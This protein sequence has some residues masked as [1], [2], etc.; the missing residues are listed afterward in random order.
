M[1]ANLITYYQNGQTPIQFNAQTENYIQQDPFL[2]LTSPFKGLSFPNSPNIVLGPR[3]VNFQFNTL[4]NTTHPYVSPN[5]QDIIDLSNYFAD[6]DC[7]YDTQ[8]GE[9][10]QIIVQVP[11][12][13]IS[14][15][16]FNIS[17]YASEQWELIPNRDIKSVVA[18]GIIC[19][20]FASPTIAGNYVVLP[21]VMK[22]AVERAYENKNTVLT[23]P[24]GSPASSASFLPYAN[25]TLNLLRGGIEGVPSVTHTLKRTAVIDNRNSNGAFQT[26]ADTERAFINANGTVNYI[27]STPDLITD[28]SIPS[29]VS[30]FMTPSYMKY[31][32][33]AG[34]DSFQFAVTAG[35]RVS[36]PT[37]QFISKNKV[38]LTQL[39]EWN[40][41]V[42]GLYYI[43]SPQ[44]HFP[45]VYAPSSNPNGYFPPI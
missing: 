15:S 45:L 28:Y 10:H 35:W 7:A 5:Y 23:L 9:I 20:P 6:W 4:G 30:A 18:S 32:S 22:I 31:I 16:D 44:S 37:Y 2:T 12:D 33:I 14:N 41:Y 42:Y 19:N 38:Q 36:P 43:I 29:S 11:W 13:T 26:A 8:E 39:F 24:P 17:L 34:I 27:Q 3:R 1:S 40:E 21:D 25:L